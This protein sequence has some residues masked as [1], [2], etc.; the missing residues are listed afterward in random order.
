MS[1]EAI[2]QLDV[3]LGSFDVSY[4]N[5][6]GGVLDVTP[7]YP[8]GTNTGYFH[9]G[10]L[11]S[12]LGVDLST[13]ENT[14]FGFHVRRSYVD[15]LLPADTFDDNDD[16]FTITKFPN[17]SDL[18]IQLAHRVGNHLFSVESLS[19]IDEFGF[20]TTANEEKDP[21]ATGELGGDFGFTSTGVRWRFD[22]GPY[23]ANTLFSYMYEVIRFD[24]F[25]D[26]TF[27]LDAQTVTLY[28][29]ST[30]QRGRH[31]LSW[32]AEIQ[33]FY[34]PVSAYLPAL[35]E[36]D[37]VDFDVT[38][39]EKVRTIDLGGIPEFTELSIFAQDT[40]D[41][42]DNLRVRFGI[43]AKES[44]NKGYDWNVMPRG[45]IVFE[46]TDTNT[47]SLA[48]GLYSGQAQPFK[49]GPVDYSVAWIHK[50]ER[51]GT[52]RIEPYY[53]ELRKLA[54]PDPNTTYSN[55]GEGS[56]TG[57]DFSYIKRFKRSFIAFS[58]AYQEAERQLNADDPR[59]YSF[60]GD[61][62]HT[63]QISASHKFNDRW[64]ISAL[65]KYATGQPY[66]PIVGTFVSI[67]PDGSPRIR[68]LYGKPYSE[69]L[70][71][72]FTLNFRVAYLR[73]LANGK[74][75]ELSLEILNMTNHDNVEEIQYDD[76]YNVDG[77][78]SG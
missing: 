68:P 67:D 29:V 35:P 60:F 54:L 58:Y 27:N 44:E 73:Q 19:A 8:A 56:S 50:S 76:N 16:D 38:T 77:D 78:E 55:T 49:T 66:T 65:A 6:I 21:D 42:L 33:R 36:E 48:A 18:N 28:H 71:D 25:G 31:E 41:L 59:M 20:N 75:L 15:L 64:S 74:S 52:I 1:P 51:F 39:A 57:I 53:K 24:L 4:G 13:A 3:Y 63:A 30:L 2:D 7:K 70:P 61:V 14:T 22:N 26:F 10:L 62:P 11:D 23:R 34:W 40:Y 46:A 72:Y 69:R 5:A 9:V 37:Q 17:Y 43:R 47:F 32:G 12:S 45:A